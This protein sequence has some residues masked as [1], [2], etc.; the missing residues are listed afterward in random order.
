[1]KEHIKSKIEDSTI[2][3]NKRKYNSFFDE[4]VKAYLILQLKSVQFSHL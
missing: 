3:V 2:E 4:T 1:M